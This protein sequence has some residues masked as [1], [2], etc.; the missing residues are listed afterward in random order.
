MPFGLCN[1]PSTFQILLDL[2]LASV[3][4]KHTLIYIDDI[5]IYSKTFDQHLR[6]IKDIITRLEAAGFR[7]KLFKCNFAVKQVSYLGHSVTELNIRQNPQHIEKIKKFPRPANTEQLHMFVGL[8]SFF[9]RFVKHFAK[10]ARP[11]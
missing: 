4:W 9:R 7:A 11:S 2:V 8:T 6:N 5:I 3:K 10:V 1:A